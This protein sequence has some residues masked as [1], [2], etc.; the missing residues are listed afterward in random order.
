MAT[1]TKREVVLLVLAAVVTAGVIYGLSCTGYTFLNRQITT[2]EIENQ[3]CFSGEEGE[4]LP[5][6]CA[7]EGVTFDKV[8][9]LPFPH[10]S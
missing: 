8:M 1:G 7:E 2:N 10:S 3:Q 5:P 6:Y 9:P 4:E